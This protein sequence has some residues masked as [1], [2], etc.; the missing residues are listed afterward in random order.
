VG[1]ERGAEDVDGQ[2]RIAAI[3]DE[4]R[5]HRER[6]APYDFIR[7]RDAE[8][9]AAREALHV[10]GGIV[11]H[12]AQRCGAAGDAEGLAGVLTWRGLWRL[13]RRGRVSPERTNGAR[14]SWTA[15]SS[16]GTARAKHALQDSG[17]A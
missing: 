2:A 13:G 14:R 5:R 7:S 8:P 1:V 17:L 6:V 16:R 4:A 9:P 12:A 11:E 10:R 3:A 15:R